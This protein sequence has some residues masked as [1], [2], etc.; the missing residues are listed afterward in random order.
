MP[1]RFTSRPLTKR[2]R[3]F[4]EEYLVDMRAGP[5]YVRAGYRAR[6]NSAESA[7]SRMLRNV[8]VRTAIVDAQNAQSQRTHVT[9]DAVLHE[10]ELVGFSDVSHYVVD[11]N[12]MLITAPGIAPDVLH[13]LERGVVRVHKSRDGMSLSV[14]IKLWDKISA[15][16]MLGAHVGLFVPVEVTTSDTG[17][18]LAVLLTQ[19]SAEAA[20]ERLVERVEQLARREADAEDDDSEPWAPVVKAT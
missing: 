13:A 20:R 16:R 15:L 6:G 2:Q 11:A 4:I 1:P 5:A 8:Q 17:T 18:G 19:A 9:A 7:G 12:G 10:L 3:R 14:E